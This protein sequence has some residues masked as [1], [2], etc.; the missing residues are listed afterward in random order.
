MQAMPGPSESCQRVEHA[1]TQSPLHTQ[2]CDIAMVLLQ[3]SIEAGMQ[4]AGW[5]PL[6]LSQPASCPNFNLL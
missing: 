4:H 3:S 2:L 6:T 5:V 1:A